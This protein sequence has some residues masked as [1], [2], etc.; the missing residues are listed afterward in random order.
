MARLSID[1]GIEHLRNGGVIAFP[2]ETCYALGCRASD[3]A[4]IERLVALKHRPE[5][6]PLPVLIASVD[7][8]RAMLP[9][10]P[11]YVLADAF[12]PGPLTLVVPAF[13]GLAAPVTAGTNMVGARISAHP[14]ARA[15]VKAL[16]EPLV[17]TSANLSGQ[18]GATT[19]EMVEESGLAADGIVDSGAV[20]HGKTTVVG[21]GADGLLFF[22]EGD[23]SASAVRRVWAPSRSFD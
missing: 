16:G 4:A 14:T 13:P 21:M 3:T 12:W 20:P 23:I 10:S 22:A 7:A 17:A 18:P 11:L 6:K 19:P 15:L 9:E 2:T 5:G 8:L 1:E